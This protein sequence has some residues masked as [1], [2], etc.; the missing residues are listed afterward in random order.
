MVR[1]DGSQAGDYSVIVGTNTYVAPPLDGGGSAGFHLVVLSRQTLALVTNASYAANPA[2][3]T[4]LQSEL[5][6]GVDETMLVVLDSMGPP[7]ALLPLPPLPTLITSFGGTSTAL[8]DASGIGYAAVYSLIGNSGLKSGSGFERSSL[9]NPQT[10]GSI[11]AVLR[12]DLALNYFPVSP[13]YV[14]LQTSAGAGQDTLLIGTNAFPAPLPLGAQSGLHLA[15][16]RADILDQAAT[17]SSVVILNQSYA[18]G[19]ANPTQSV[20]ELSRLWQDLAAYQNQ[21]ASGQVLLLLSSI[22]PQPFYC[23]GNSSCGIDEFAQALYLEAV[24]VSLR[25]RLG[26]VADLGSLV[27]GTY[28]S[29]VGVPWPGGTQRPQTV[30]NRSWTLAPGMNGSVNL[31]V[32]MHPNPQG[33]FVPQAS[34]TVGGVDYRLFEIASQ[35]PVPWPVAPNASLA[36]CAAGDQECAAYQWISL[37]LTGNNASIRDEYIVTTA[38]FAGYTNLL[39]ALTYDP[40]TSNSFSETTFNAVKSQLYLELGDVPYVQGLYSKYVGLVNSM[41]IAETA[42]LLATLG[43]VISDIQAPP[44]ATATLNAEGILRFLVQIGAAA[45][46]IDPEVKAALGVVNALFDLGYSRNRDAAGNGTNVIADAVSNLA[47]DIGTSFAHNRDGVAATFQEILTDWGKLDTVASLVNSVPGAGNGFAWEIGTTGNLLT[48]MEPAFELSFYQALL[49]TRFQQVVFTNV[50]F[51]NPNAYTYQ[52]DCSISQYGAFCKCYSDVY[53]PP[54]FDYLAVELP[55]PVGQYM[56]YVIATADLQYPVQNLMQTTLPGLG[57]YPTDMLQ[58]VGTWTGVLPV[59]PP[60]GWQDYLNPV[61]GYCDGDL[62]VE[63]LNGSP[64]RLHSRGQAGLRYQL[65][66]TPVLGGLWQSTGEAVVAGEERMITL[67]P[68]LPDS[69]TAFF[70]LRRR[71]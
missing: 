40:S 10:S 31:S 51:S 21:I 45:T 57:V 64:L 68:S 52:D 19:I 29:M 35:P 39:A 34:D 36:P 37:K 55:G 58:G 17:N 18:T 66:W 62:A 42:M 60:Q 9:V 16:L 27:A 32:L 46:T 49:P 47:A 12:P 59:V 28:Y 6:G 63:P 23:A 41:A 8:Y 71:D 11:N 22:G 70:R 15:I 50:P 26:A 61:G 38:D 14:T 44:N 3:L 24:M 43:N 25:V 2:S 33:W 54:A 48:V 4:A 67:T 56:V 13:S 69:S 53:V 20:S 65:E 5:Q 7:G 1:G 30:E